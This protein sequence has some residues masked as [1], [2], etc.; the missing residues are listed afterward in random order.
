[1]PANSIL[2]ATKL[3]LVLNARNFRAL[4]QAQLTPQ[5]ELATMQLAKPSSRGSHEMRGEHARLL[6][7]ALL[8]EMDEATYLAAQVRLPSCTSKD[9]TLALS[10]HRLRNS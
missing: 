6:L 1:M 5:F 10:L 2:L 3:C 8:P 4:F 9:Y 7:N